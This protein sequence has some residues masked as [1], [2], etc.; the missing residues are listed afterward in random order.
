MCMDNL[1]LSCV[2]VF[3][4]AAQSEPNWMIG[5]VVVIVMLVVGVVIVSSYAACKLKAQ[6][7]V[8]VKQ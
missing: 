7:G 6:N 3:T 4:A 2:C 5:F 1:Y 8:S